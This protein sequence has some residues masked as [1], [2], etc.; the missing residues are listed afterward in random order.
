[1]GIYTD[2]LKRKA[3]ITMGQDP[4]TVKGGLD[5]RTPTQAD[6]SYLQLA[7]STHVGIDFKAK[8]G[9][10][11]YA[12]YDAR[13]WVGKQTGGKWPSGKSYEAAEYLLLTD[14]EGFGLGLYHLDTIEVRSG[15]VKAGQRIGTAG[16]KGKATG[17]HLHAQVFKD[18]ACYDVY[19]YLFNKDKDKDK[20][21]DAGVVADDK[22]YNWAN[23][24]EWEKSISPKRMQV[25]TPG[26][27]NL[28]IRRSP[29]T[30]KDEVGFLA[31]GA[32]FTV[33]KWAELPDG[34]IWARL[35][36]KPW[37]WV[38]IKRGQFFAE[39][40]KEWPEVLDKGFYVV[41]DSPDN[42]KSQTGAFR[43]LS[44]AKRLADKHGQKVIA[45]DG[46]VV[47]ES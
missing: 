33:D 5:P 10:P 32:S 36:G 41:R 8:I 1:M 45:P 46:T 19:W 2:L 40:V 37:N 11:V 9:D 34:Q 47:Y 6:G 13:A 35:Q 42:T 23:T 22:Y 44:N 43:V 3:T 21:K 17:P 30:D 38:C 14:A 25:K 28:R 7:G 15:A 20:S 31:N 26:S 24:D 27:V 18:G 29:G 12:P 16:A 4:K 39:E